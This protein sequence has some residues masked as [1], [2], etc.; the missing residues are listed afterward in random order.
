MSPPPPPAPDLAARLLD[1]QVA[2]LLADAEPDRIGPL[3]EAEISAGLDAAARLRLTDMVNREQVAAVAR[4]YAT[5]FTIPGSIPELANEIADRIYA[6]SAHD[7]HRLSEV[8][9]ARHVEAFVTKLLELPLVRD[10][11]LTSPLLTEVAAEL[12]YRVATEA[13]AQNRDLAARIPGVSTLLG[14]GG[15]LLGRA[16]PDAAVEFETRMRELS[17]QTARLL[18]RRAGS[19][20]DQREDP[21]IT[22]TVLDLYRNGADRPMGAFREYVT[23]EDLEDLFVLGYDFWLTLR[24]TEYLAELIDEGVA[25]FFDKYAEAT[26]LDLLEEFNIT[27]ADLIEEA[28]RFAPPILATLRANGMLEAFLRRRLA[29]FYASPAAR[30]LLGTP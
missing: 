18:L 9:A 1:A 10:R 8:I 23:Q 22:E 29:P 21:W 5:T 26:L 12:L 15:S 20:T 13:A 2:F 11:L 25:F 27:R 30:E 14:A 16:A 7:E 4:K 17:A 28:E 6:H 19:H 24:E 3:L